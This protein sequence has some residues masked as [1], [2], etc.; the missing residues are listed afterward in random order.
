MTLFARISTLTGR[1][2]QTFDDTIRRDFPDSL[3]QQSLKSVSLYQK[4][5]PLSPGLYRLDIVIKDTTSNNVGVVN[6]RL[7]V[8]PF[9]ED[10][11]QAS[12]LI[13]A[14]DIAPVAAKDIGV[15]MFVIG[16]MKVRPKLD[17][18]FANNQV[19]GLYMQL[20]NLKVDEKSHKN[21]T[22]VDI[23]IFQGD[24]QVKHVVQTSEQLH[25]SGDQLTV[26]EAL[27]PGALP[28][29]KYRLQITATDTLA[30]TTISRTADFTVTPAIDTTA[31][32]TSS[33][34]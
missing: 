24:Q 19:L 16:S 11:I 15:G 30:N 8:A 28:P 6:T 18:S 7:A 29:G 12:S 14:D 5:V 32:Q 17:Q 31:A 26:Q 34:R 13:L 4:A 9:D 2:V 23:Q 1:V 22:S 10:K 21:N 27:P 33:T 3:L 25:Q 20:Y